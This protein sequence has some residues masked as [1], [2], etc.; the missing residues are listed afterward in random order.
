MQTLI[1]TG[2][3]KS[4]IPHTQCQCWLH[5]HSISI[6]TSL[7]QQSM[8]V[9]LPMASLVYFSWGLFLRPGWCARVLR[10]SSNGSGLTGQASTRLE[11]TT[12]LGKLG[13]Q[14]GYYLWYLVLKWASGDT[15]WQCQLLHMEKPATSWLLTT[16]DFHLYVI[17]C[18]KVVGNSASCPLSSWSTERHCITM[19]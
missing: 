3:D 14:I 8:C 5:Q 13:H 7:N 10:W 4:R 15:I 12:W 1:V 2:F 19:D 9:S 16:P 18:F 6:S 11:I 17:I